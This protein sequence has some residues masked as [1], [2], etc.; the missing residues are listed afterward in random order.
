VIVGS[1]TGVR[2]GFAGS[3]GI[4][5]GAGD[6]VAIGDLAEQFVKNVD[7]AEMTPLASIA[8]TSSWRQPSSTV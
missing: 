8:Y 3:S 6:R 5:V 4:G 7:G 2:V 1:G